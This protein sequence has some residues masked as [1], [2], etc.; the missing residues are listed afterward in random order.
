MWDENK[1][2]IVDVAEAYQSISLASLMSELVITA[3]AGGMTSPSPNKA[4]I[5]FFAV[6][7]TQ[8]G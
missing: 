7:Q 6:Y 5:Y 3:K 4:T 1:V 8:D 2:R